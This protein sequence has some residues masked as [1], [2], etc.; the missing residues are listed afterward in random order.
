MYTCD[1]LNWPRHFSL[2]GFVRND[3]TGVGIHGPLTQDVNKGDSCTTVV[4]VIVVVVV[5]LASISM[6]IC[7]IHHGHL[8]LT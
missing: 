5:V 2:D 7:M 6:Y 4:V 1:R 8:T 3:S